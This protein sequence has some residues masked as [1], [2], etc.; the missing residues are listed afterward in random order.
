M[1]SMTRRDPYPFQAIIRRKGCP[2]QTRTFE[3]RADA[4]AWG[5]WVESK[6]NLGQFRDLRPLDQLTL[7]DLLQRYG[8]EVTLNKRGAVAESKRIKQLRRHPLALRP[9]STLCAGDFAA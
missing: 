7:G 8:E 4:E 3:T 9:M 1:A 6:T 5:R 2:S